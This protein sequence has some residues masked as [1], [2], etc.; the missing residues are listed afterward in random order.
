MNFFR[1][2]TFSE[3]RFGVRIIAVLL[4]A[5]MTIPVGVPAQQPVVQP[6]SRPKV[7][8]VFEGGGRWDLR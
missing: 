1:A 6:A 5:L 3:T 2:M 8:L 4:A 7:A